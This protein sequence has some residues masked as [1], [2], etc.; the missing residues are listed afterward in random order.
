ME[1]LGLADDTILMFTSDNGPA[2][3]ARPDQVPQGMSTDT[4]RY[5]CGFNGQKGSLYEGGMRVPKVLRWLDQCGNAR[6]ALETGAS[7][8][9][10]AAQD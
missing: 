7:P 2:F 6:R 8:I 5:N 3:G 1:D 9:S 4:R 10:A